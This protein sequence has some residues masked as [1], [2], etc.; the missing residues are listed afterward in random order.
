MPVGRRAAAEA[1]RLSS[2]D[3]KPSQ[4]HIPLP[5]TSTGTTST[6][7]RPKHPATNSIRKQIQETWKIYGNG[8][9]PPRP[10][11]LRLDPRPPAEAFDDEVSEFRR[12]GA[13][14]RRSPAVPVA[15]Q[16]D[17]NACARATP[18]QSLAVFLGVED[19]FPSV[20]SD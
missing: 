6:D 5:L 8:R 14:G 17:A 10:A 16:C 12:G 15:R 4:G 7:I 3:R 1:S 13:L 2:C 18:E 11:H 9:P 19:S 20:R